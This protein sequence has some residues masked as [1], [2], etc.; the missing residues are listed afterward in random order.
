MKDQAKTRL[1]KVVET[2]WDPT[3]GLRAIEEVEYEEKMEKGKRETKELSRCWGFVDENGSL[4]IDIKYHCVW[5]F[6]DGLSKVCI[7]S[8]WGVI[9]TAGRVVIP[10]N[11]QTLHFTSDGLVQVQV[12]GKW[13]CLNRD[14]SAVVE[15]RY[16]Y[17]FP[18]RESFAG[19]KKGC[20]YGFVDIQ[21]NEIIA[22]QFDEIGHISS[23]GSV[24]VRI[25]STYKII[26]LK[27]N[28]K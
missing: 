4:V 11:Y 16:D 17:I 27:G 23:D 26:N 14:G 3:E 13:G 12:L 6:R 24:K 22:P 7:G 1:Y 18:F 20:K 19:V 15:P 21:G 25:G 5:K 10:I 8:K 28:K 9:D 2:E